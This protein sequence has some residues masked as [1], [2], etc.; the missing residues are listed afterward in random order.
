MKR[1][2]LTLLLLGLGQAAQGQPAE[3]IT[4][5]TIGIE[6]VKP[7]G[8]HHLS[9]EANLDNLR[10]VGP[11]DKEFQEAAARYGNAPVIAFSK[12]VEPYPDLNPSFK[13]NIRPL[14]ALAGRSAS[15]ILQVVLPA[16]L[17]VFP[18]MTIEQAPMETVV[19]G[20]AGSY[21]RFTYTL[22]TAD[23]SLPTTSELWIIPKGSYFFMIGAGTRQDEANGT[24]AEI[25]SILSTISFDPQ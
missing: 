21:A 4:N 16:M 6:V 13:I 11:D 14:G 3:K 7:E 5:R 9:A 1:F 12:Y 25:Q 22:K 24:R 10:R 19:A 18:D 17:R 2:V 23:L 20:Q 15:D 8:W